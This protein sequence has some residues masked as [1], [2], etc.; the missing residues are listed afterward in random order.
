MA[1]AV[2]GGDETSVEKSLCGSM[3]RF[4]VFDA[5]SVNKRLCGQWDGNV[6]RSRDHSPGGWLRDYSPDLGKMGSERTGM[7]LGSVPWP[8]HRGGRDGQRP[9]MAKDAIDKM[10]RLC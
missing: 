8:I 9:C 4:E 2:S 3:S 7:M 5:D 6:G 1:F 10:I